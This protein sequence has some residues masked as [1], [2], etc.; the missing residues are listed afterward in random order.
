MARPVLDLTGKTFGTWRVLYITHREEWRSLAAEWVVECEKGAW[1]TVR[2]FDAKSA[3][4]REKCS[5][6]S[7]HGQSVKKTPTY[8]SWL[9]MRERCLNPK[10]HAYMRY[11]GRGIA[12]AAE[13]SDFQTFLFDLGERPEGTTLDRIDANGDYTPENCRWATPK[14]QNRNTRAT[15]L[16]ERMADEI[17][18]AAAEGI[19][20]RK[21]ASSYGVSES[22]VS[23]I[24]HGKVWA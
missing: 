22:V 4:G 13:W 6:C 16:T 7:R 9:A 10:H 24:V 5:I 20:Q 12:I 14:Q 19:Q 2:S 17:R 1:H 11:G 3:E 8:S 21:L 18:I 23:N 15:K